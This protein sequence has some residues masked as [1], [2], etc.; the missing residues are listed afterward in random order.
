MIDET[1]F[2]DPDDYEECPECGVSWVGYEIPEEH[3]E[4]FGNKTHYKKTVIGTEYG[5]DAPAGY[6]YDGISEWMCTA[7]QTRWGRWTG[8]KLGTNELEER[9]GG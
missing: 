7:C 8:K 3:R 9:Y 4:M 5:H 1:K 2:T 6:H